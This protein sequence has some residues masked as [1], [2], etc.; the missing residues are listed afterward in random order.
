M[1]KEEA[2]NKIVHTAEAE[3]GYLEKKSNNNL[4]HKTA[5]AGSA[6]YTK[7]WQ[8]VKPEYQGQ[9]WCA[10][11]VSWCFWQA[12]GLEQAKKLLKHWPY[13][14]CPELGRL[15][16]GENTP[17]AG[18]I[19]VFYR[20]KTFAHTGIVVNAEGER[21]T[22]V[23]GNT[24]GASGII[25]NGGGVCRKSYR[26]SQLPGIRFCRPD[27]RILEKEENGSESSSLN[28][29]PKWKGYVTASVL[30]VRRWAGTEYPKLQSC[31]VLPQNA[32][33]EVCDT[34]KDSGGA[35]WHYIR[36]PLGIYGFVS[37]QYIEERQG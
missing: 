4:D 13:V 25:A 22:T 8:D 6:N 23:E 2:I 33:V 29:T 1:K 16:A 19:V 7:Y 26:S 34:I 3:I 15:F 21:F 18:D 5:N 35:D 36:T 12:F 30:N 24:S 9:P 27:Y 10:A 14:H 37:A 32:E 28:K 20:N 31:P 17:K 11:F